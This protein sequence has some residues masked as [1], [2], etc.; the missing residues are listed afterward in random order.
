[1]IRYNLSASM[2]VVGWRSDLC[3][4]ILTLAVLFVH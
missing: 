2:V 3:T 4:W 1:M